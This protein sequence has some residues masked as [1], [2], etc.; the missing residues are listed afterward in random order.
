MLEIAGRLLSFMVH[1]ITNTKYI[2]CSQQLKNKMGTMAQGIFKRLI[3]LLKN[4]IKT[5]HPMKTKSLCNCMDTL[6]GL[7]IFQFLKLN[8][9][10][11]SLKLHEMEFQVQLFEKGAPL[12]IVPT[13]M[14]IWESNAYVS[15]NCSGYHCHPC[16]FRVKSCPHYVGIFNS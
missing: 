15:G 11:N 6:Q 4:V 10:Q 9:K 7:V 14:S 13:V 2:S 16:P 5:D 1:L 3:L 12:N 8:Q